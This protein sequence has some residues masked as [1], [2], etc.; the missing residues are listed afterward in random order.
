[1]AEHQSQKVDEFGGGDPLLEP[2]QKAQQLQ[3]AIDED[4]G[5]DVRRVN[6][7]GKILPKALKTVDVL[8]ENSL[9]GS[10]KNED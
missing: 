1:M 5:T 7:K 6:S 9:L 4:D 2:S 8:D 10:P 3:K